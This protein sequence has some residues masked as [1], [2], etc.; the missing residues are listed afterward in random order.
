MPKPAPKTTREVGSRGKPV[1]VYMTEAALKDWYL[2]PK[3]ER[4]KRVQAMARQYAER[5]EIVLAANPT[6][7]KEDK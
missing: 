1:L 5:V 3:W 4:T 7:Q 6:K 2:I